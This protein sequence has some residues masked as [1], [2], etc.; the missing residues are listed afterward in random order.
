MLA[1]TVGETLAALDA[2]LER[3][4]LVPARD[5]LRRLRQT[6]P[7]WLGANAAAVAVREI[8]LAFATEG[9][10]ASRNQVRHFLAS[11]PSDSAALSLVNLARKFLARQRMADA[12][13]LHDEVKTARGDSDRV[14]AALRDLKL[15]DD[16]QDVLANRE[17]TL[18]A[19]DEWM[20]RGQWLEA[21]TLLGRL[22]KSAPPWATEARVELQVREVRLLLELG[23][24]PPALQVFRELA[25]KPGP[26][27]VAAFRLVRDYVVAGE[28]ARAVLLT[29]EAARLLPGE[30]AVDRLKRE[31]Q[32]ALPPPEI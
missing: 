7:T 24:K 8:E 22:Q 17:T 12:R 21:E 32:V 23:K 3:D 28:S 6:N 15:G 18:R 1:G 20:S 31:V 30:P 16:L 27:R 25:G 9:A 2:L 19:L 4:S 10:L 11:F 29:E 14:A 13:V 5:L 26:A